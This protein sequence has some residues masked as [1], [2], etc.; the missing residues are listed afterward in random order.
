[1]AVKPVTWVVFMAANL[2]NIGDSLLERLARRLGGRTAA[3]V[4]YPTTI[5][6]DA[7]VYRKRA[8]GRLHERINNQK[9]KKKNTVLC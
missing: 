7:I 6:V 1:M 2:A 3:S 5:Q 9:K 8:G 4:D